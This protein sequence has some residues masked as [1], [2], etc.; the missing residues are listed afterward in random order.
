MSEK[1]SN[2]INLRVLG[3]ALSLSL[4]AIQGTL[5]LDSDTPLDQVKVNRHLQEIEGVLRFICQESLAGVV[6]MMREIL[7]KTEDKKIYI[8]RAILCASVIG[9]LDYFLTDVRLGQPVMAYRLMPVWQQLNEHTLIATINPASLI[10]LKMLKEK[11]ISTFP[12]FILQ[13]GMESSI[14]KKEIEHALLELIREDAGTAKFRDASKKI[15]IAVSKIC[16]DHPVA[17]QRYFWIVARLVIHTVQIKKGADLAKAKKIIS[18]VVHTIRQRSF[19]SWP[20]LSDVLV[21]E[22][23]YFLFESDA[24]EADVDSSIQMV[25]SWFR[26]DLQF[27]TTSTEWQNLPDS[28]DLYSLV[29]GLDALITKISDIDIQHSRNELAVLSSRMIRIPWLVELGSMLLEAL[30]RYL[31]K[32]ELLFTIYALSLRESIAKCSYHHNLPAVR[33]QVFSLLNTIVQCSSSEELHALMASQSPVATYILVRPDAIT[34]L[35]S[36]LVTL[37]TGV[38]PQL[39]ILFASG[40][41]L[42]AAKLMNQILLTIRT[43]LMFLGDTQGI[44]I[45]NSLIQSLD[46]QTIHTPEKNESDSY[47]FAQSWAGLGFYIDHLFSNLKEEHNLPSFLKNLPKEI[48]S[49]TTDEVSA[50]RT[51]QDIFIIEASERSRILRK[52]ITLFSTGV[53]KS[54]P[55]QIAIEI[56][57]LAGSSATVGNQEMH[58]QAIALEQIINHAISLAPNEQYSFLP[59]LVN[60]LMALEQQFKTQYDESL[61]S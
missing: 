21:R 56:H 57:A 16:N 30:D 31:G 25:F 20:N 22:S 7:V 46:G 37:L 32:D 13:E 29:D 41:R 8:D 3:D 4:Q 2:L 55:T 54:L 60:G 43:S 50:D 51:L 12:E 33:D 44:G 42:A 47:F 38:E 26:L 58:Q 59:E 18:S 6:L 48:P 52:Q 45:I 36:T 10:S 35:K 14:E 49:E 11:E 27:R 15:G 34:A 17:R 23:L 61:S 39:E 9:K 28:R 40:D 1:K 5:S 53:S 24:I 19:T